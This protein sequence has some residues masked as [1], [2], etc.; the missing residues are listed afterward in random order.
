MVA[1]NPKDRPTINEILNSEWLSDLRNANEEKLLYY[2]KKMID[3][4]N[5]I[6]V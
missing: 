4:L 6:K 2:K 1:Y 5:N 3:E